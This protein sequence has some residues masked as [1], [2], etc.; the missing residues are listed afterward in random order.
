MKTKE[1]R[2]ITS[3]AAHL[4]HKPRKW[5]VWL[6]GTVPTSTPPLSTALS[7]S[8]HCPEQ[9]PETLDCLS[10]IDLL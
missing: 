1:I 4:C 5:D 10:G 6:D 2:N 7:W 3:V 9:I 8:S